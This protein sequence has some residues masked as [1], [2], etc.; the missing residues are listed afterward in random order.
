MYESRMYF[1]NGIVSYEL[2]ALNGEPLAFVREDRAD[3][4]R[5][6]HFLKVTD[7]L[8]GEIFVEG[9]ALHLNIPRLLRSVWI[10]I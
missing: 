7:I 8:D 10:P 6:N 3:N 4:A 5:K 9:K 2:D 1:T